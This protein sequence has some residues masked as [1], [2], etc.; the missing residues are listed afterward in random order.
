MITALAVLLSSLT[1]P[2]FGAIIVFSTYV[3]GHATNILIDLP[4]QFEGTFAERVLTVVYYILPNL[5]NFDIRAEAAN[6]EP[7]APGYVLWALGYGAFY[8]IML[9]V[10]ASI[11]FED[12]DV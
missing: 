7:V 4:E 2:I 3:V 8:T 10:L 1:S 6:A 12:K 11:A 9:L 5:S